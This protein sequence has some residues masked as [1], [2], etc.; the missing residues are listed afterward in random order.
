MLQ[1]DF[2]DLLNGYF[3]INSQPIPPNQ[4]LILLFL[5]AE[6]DEEPPAVE[7]LPALASFAP[8]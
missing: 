8:S 2:F 4:P 6:W 1:Q 5:E 3:L 7:E